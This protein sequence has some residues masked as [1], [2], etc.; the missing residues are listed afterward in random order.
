[1]SRTGVGSG[2]ILTFARLRPPVEGA[3]DDGKSSRG[4]SR[5][6]A[7]EVHH[8]DD[9]KDEVCVV[10][11]FR[12]CGVFVLM[13]GWISRASSPFATGCCLF[14][15]RSGSSTNMETLGCFV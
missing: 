10:F 4:G 5:R 15:L 8:G 11:F 7:Y 9:G 2:E 3:D 14:V 1:M 6:V 13:F 12:H